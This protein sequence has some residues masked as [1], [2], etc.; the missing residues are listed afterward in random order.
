MTSIMMLA[1]GGHFHFY[2]VSSGDG[3]ISGIVY[4]SVDQQSWSNGQ[5]VGLYITGLLVQSQF[6][7]SLLPSMAEVP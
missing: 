3:A 4:T 5:G 2:V 6:Y 7:Q 1:L